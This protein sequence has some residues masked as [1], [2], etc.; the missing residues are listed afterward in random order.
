MSYSQ[1][2]TRAMKGLRAAEASDN[3][4]E[5]RF[6]RQTLDGVIRV[7]RKH[8]LITRGQ[9]AEIRRE[10]LANQGTDDE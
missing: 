10:Y 7:E 6:W 8:N 1:A 3:R 5:R 2:L 4:R 9:A